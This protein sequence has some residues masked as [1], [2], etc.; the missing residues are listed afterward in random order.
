VLDHSGAA[1]AELVVH[2]VC[3]ALDALEVGEGM[4]LRASFGV[5]VGGGETADP[6]ALLRAA[7]A[8]MYEA[9]RAGDR[10]RLAG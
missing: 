2:R 9:K 7:D 8:A 6:E 5:V 4:S 1:E 10:M 3:D